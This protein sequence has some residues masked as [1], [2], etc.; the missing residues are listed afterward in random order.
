MSKI[1]AKDNIKTGWQVEFENLAATWADL[2]IGF[3]EGAPVV[4]FKNLKF[5]Y[6]LSQDNK[7][8]KTS[9]FP[10]PNIRYI[11]TD[12]EYLVIE[13]LRLETETEYTLNLWAENAGERLETETTFTTPRPRRPYYSWTWDSGDKKWV[14]PIPYPQDGERYMWNEEN[15]AWEPFEEGG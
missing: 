1:L 11:R 4:E 14:A 13:R 8:L 10:P 2:H 9:Q 15:Q 5:G 12:Q 6:T 7:T 3:T